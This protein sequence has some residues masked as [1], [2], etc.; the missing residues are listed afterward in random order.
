MKSLLNIGLTLLILLCCGQVQA[1]FSQPPPVDKPPPVQCGSAMF[2][3]HRCS[4]LRG[5]H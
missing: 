5:L 3:L 2:A 4:Q 1:Q